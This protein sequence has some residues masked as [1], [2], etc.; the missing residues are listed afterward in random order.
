[1]W[2]IRMMG[3]NEMRQKVGR[4][5]L[6]VRTAMVR[7]EATFHGLGYRKEMIRRGVVMRTTRYLMEKRVCVML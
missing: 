1:M 5:N 6:R 3:I 2:G 7:I 4:L